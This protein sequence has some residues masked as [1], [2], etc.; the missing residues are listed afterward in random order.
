MDIYVTHRQGPA[1]YVCMYTMCP[2]EHCPSRHHECDVDFVL[3]HTIHSITHRLKL[4]QSME[5]CFT[6][7]ET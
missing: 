3:E 1:T 7:D 2:R 6:N 5:R 4:A